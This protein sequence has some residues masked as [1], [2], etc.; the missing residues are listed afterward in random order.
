MV[1]IIA[2]AVIIRIRR[3]DGT[4]RVIREP[5]GTQVLVGSEQERASGPL[6][7]KAQAP[8]TIDPA[9]IKEVAALPAEEQV[10]RVVAKLKELNPGY[11]GK[12]EH[13]IENGQIMLFDIRS[14]NITNLSP[15]RA[16]DKVGHLKCGGLYFAGRLIDSPLSDLRPLQGLPVIHLECDFSQLSDLSPLK[17]VPF[18]TT[19]WC[20]KTKVADLAP[21]RGIP[22]R[23][24]VID[25]TLVR[26]LSPLGGMPL[27]NLSCYGTKVTDLSPLKACPL[28]SIRCDFV[29]NRDTDV[30]RS[31]KTLETINGLPVAEFWKR[32][33]AGK[34]PSPTTGEG[35]AAAGDGMSIEEEPD[36]V[37]IDPAFIQEVATLPAEQQVARVV[38]K[39]KELN[40]GYD[41]KEEH[42]IENGVVVALTIRS[43]AVRDIS[44]VRALVTLKG[45][46]CT[47]SQWVKKCLLS[48]LTPLVGMT[49]NSLQIQNTSVSDLLPLQGMPMKLLWCYGTTVQDLSPIKAMPLNT[50]RCDFV[51]QRDTAILR[52]ITTLRQINGLPVA[53][54]WEQVEAGRIP[55]PY[56]GWDKDRKGDD[57]LI[58]KTGDRPTPTAP[59]IDPAFIKEVA[60][61]PAEEQVA[62]VV[63]KLK[64]LNP[65]YDG[66]EEHKIENGQVVQLLIPNT[67]VIEIWPIRALAKLKDLNCGG[68]NRTNKSPCADLTPLQGL[69]LGKV[70]CSNSDVA[71][72]SPLRG[73]P[74]KELSCWN[75][76]I[77][78]LSPLQG[79]PLMSL[80][81][82]STLVSDLSPLRGMPLTALLC[83]STKVTDLSPI[84][85]MPL[86]LLRC[87]FDLKRDTDIVRSIKTLKQINGLPVAEFWKQVEAGTIPTP[88]TGLGKIPPP[89]KGLDK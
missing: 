1:G 80:T 88:T 53:E 48:D 2:L 46:V 84:K 78:D 25:S 63:A 29:P 74:L 87:D 36:A 42:K 73:L 89:A 3:P 9:F 20:R 57:A 61:L 65:G 79:M 21:L 81:V 10:N 45:L 62:R 40:P 70:M 55:Q 82:N 56:S 31:I 76:Q 47:P 19:L 50:L 13:K 51:P 11:D 58:E 28:K 30:L 8:T 69:A 59:S 43:K 35:K 18:L 64:E 67:T 34:I 86:N 16:L 38:A 14:N 12:E 68:L 37:A 5:D 52:S 60:A 15:V 32:V 26:D 24:L 39:L 83:H 72:L 54:F 49:L 75:T 27:R 23:S 66:K 44:P 4:E 22:L 85:D 77:V 6:A 17:N 33:E 71:D 7:T 41:G